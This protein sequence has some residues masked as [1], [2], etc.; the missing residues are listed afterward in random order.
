MKQCSLKSK[1]DTTLSYLK[2]IYTHTEQYVSSDYE[3]KSHR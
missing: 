2:G 1:T 3:V